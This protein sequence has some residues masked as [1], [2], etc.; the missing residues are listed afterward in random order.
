M[1]GTRCYNFIRMYRRYL[2]RIFDIIGSVMG[3]VLTS[4]VLFGVGIWLV[5]INRGS[6][7]FFQPRPGLN[8]KVFSI[9]K[10]RTMNDKRDS[11]GK[12]LPGVER[13]HRIGRFL[14]ATSIDELPQMINV[15][16]GQMSFIGPRPLLKEYLPLY[17]TE[18]ARRH[19]VRPGITGWAQVNGRNAISWIQKFEQDIWYVDHVNLSL[20]IKIVWMTIQKIMIRD[21]IN[22]N[23]YTTMIPFDV[24]YR[25]LDINKRKIQ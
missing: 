3:L 10:F 23:E 15:L 9:I 16:L 14:R 22:A 4:P 20:D 5:I 12:L 24:Y 13:I 8:G 11:Q 17:S 1:Y 18:Q 6:P 2:K 25:Q 21:G 19:D 7:F